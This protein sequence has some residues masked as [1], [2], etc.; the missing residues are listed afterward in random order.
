MRHLLESAPTTGPQHGSFATW[1]PGLAITFVLSTPKQSTCVAPVLWRPSAHVGTRTSS[2][3]LH[4]ACTQPPVVWRVTHQGDTP[5]ASPCVVHALK[6]SCPRQY[7]HSHVCLCHRLLVSWPHTC[8]LG[9][10]ILESRLIGPN[11]RT[12]LLSGG[13]HHNF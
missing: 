5:S 8:S 7:P 12:F 1:Q 11:Q 9:G 10:D 3:S 13:L 6:A 4:V 2:I